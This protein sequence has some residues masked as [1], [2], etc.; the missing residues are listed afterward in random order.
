[1]FTSIDK[2]IIAALGAILFFI[3]EYTNIEPDFITEDLIQSI[4]AVITAALVYFVPNK[5]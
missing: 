5:S 4:A 1:M 3:T 2:A